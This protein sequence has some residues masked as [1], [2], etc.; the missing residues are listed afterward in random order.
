MCSI[1]RTMDVNVIS[2]TGFFKVIFILFLIFDLSVL[3][4]RLLWQNEAE[5][6]AEPTLRHYKHHKNKQKHNEDITEVYSKLK[7]NLRHR[8]HHHQNYH[9]TTTTTTTKSTPTTI[10]PSTTTTT[11]P[12]TTTT[13]TTTTKSIGTPEEHRLR[14]SNKFY[15]AF[16]LNHDYNHEK[17]NVRRYINQS[18]Y[19]ISTPS[20][21]WKKLVSSTPYNS[22]HHTRQSQSAR[23]FY[24]VSKLMQNRLF[25]RDGVSYSTR[26]PKMRH[27]YDVLKVP[28]K[29]RV[30]IKPVRK[31]FDRNDL[32]D[33][34]RLMDDD[35]DDDDDVDTIDWSTK[36]RHLKLKSS[37]KGKKLQ[38]DYDDDYE[39]EEEEDDFTQ[40]KHLDSTFKVS[41]WFCFCVLTIRDKF[42][43]TERN[44]MK[45]SFFLSLQNPRMI[46]RC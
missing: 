5:I 13:R 14:H 11:Q 37:R 33:D 9:H 24:N 31:A 45:N 22:K 10:E 18:S 44:K 27:P 3:A 38:D 46:K 2:I 25:D 43:Y 36:K 35:V 29:E 32:W 8:S 4:E 1:Q 12:P 41:F 39:E 34:S 20:N 17:S 42:R 30:R 40:T 7:T 16:N 19:P 28:Y 15:Q 6:N 21:P 26:P 23:N